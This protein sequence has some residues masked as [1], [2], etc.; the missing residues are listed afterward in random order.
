M[1]ALKMLE[2]H[3]MLM[4]VSGF[5]AGFVPQFTFCKTEIWFWPPV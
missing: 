2:I 3:A 1:P 4:S 5:G